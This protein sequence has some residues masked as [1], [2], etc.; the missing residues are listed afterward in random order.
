M[1]PGRYCRQWPDCIILFQIKTK[2]HFPKM[3]GCAPGW[4]QLELPR[5]AA[6][7]WKAGFGWLIIFLNGAR[8][9]S[10]SDLESHLRHHHHHLPQPERGGERDLTFVR[11]LIRLF[12][13]HRSGEN[14]FQFPGG[15]VD[16]N[17]MCHRKSFKHAGNIMPGN[18]QPTFRQH[19]S[20]RWKA[21]GNDFHKSIHQLSLKPGYLEQGS[22]VKKCVFEQ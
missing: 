11:E 7:I 4:W 6:E 10:L 1:P 15:T 13:G 2:N 22:A 20:R 17:L 3:W 12:C 16:N 5:A 8:S 19:C 21:D 14:Q 18:R 9:W